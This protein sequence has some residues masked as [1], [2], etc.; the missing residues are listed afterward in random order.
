MVKAILFDLDG[1]LVDACEL[2]Y[3][4]LNRALQENSGF[5]ISREEHLSTFNGLPTKKKLEILSSQNR[6]SPEDFGYIDSL[7]QGY[8]KLFIQH[9]KK[10][11]AKVFMLDCLKR[12][13]IKV[14]CVTNCS[15]DTAEEML[16]RT[17]M[18]P[19]I[20]L[21]ITNS[22]VT[23]PKPHPEGYQK[24]M[25]LL[26]VSPEETMIIE[27]ADK[28]VEAAQAAGAKVVR[29]DYTSVIWKNIKLYMGRV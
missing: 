7:K 16:N 22:D 27:D 12:S 14:A 13:G 2:H 29:M 21:L 9:M 19:F 10:D 15:K 11:S 1:T 26:N 18:L 23:H 4:A 24:A 5:S 28:G 6:V 25:F 20:G 17:G 3:E 8:T